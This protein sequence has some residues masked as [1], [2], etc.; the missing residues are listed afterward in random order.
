MMKS[1][2]IIQ[3]DKL[4]ETA[5]SIADG[6]GGDVKAWALGMI[7]LAMSMSYCPSEHLDERENLLWWN[8]A[9]FD[10]RP[11]R[12]LDVQEVACDVLG[13]DGMYPTKDTDLG[14]VLARFIDVPLLALARDE[15]AEARK[16]ER[17]ANEFLSRMFGE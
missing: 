8:V 5:K 7:H 6:E 17:M 11:S 16:A 14:K 3:R 4:T 1:I 15:E 9:I 2:N 10:T 12:F 13:Q